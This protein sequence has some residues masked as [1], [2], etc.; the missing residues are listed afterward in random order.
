M[1]FQYYFL[2][3]VDIGESFALCQLKL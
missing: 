1:I 3:T 2:Y